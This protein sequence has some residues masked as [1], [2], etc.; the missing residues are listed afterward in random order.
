MK[1]VLSLVLSLALACG[2][3]VGL[4]ACGGEEK[5]DVVKP[6]NGIKTIAY[7][8]MKVGLITLHDEK[9]TYDLNFI[10]AFK[11]ACEAKGVK[12]VITRNI[13]ETNKAY[14][15]AADLVDQGCNLIFADSFGHEPFILKAA[16][17]FPDVQFC[18]AAGVKAHGE[19]RGNFHD[20]F[21]N[22]YEG[23]FLAGVAGGEKIKELVA[24]DANKVTT[25]NGEKFVKIGYV[26]AYTYAEV[27]SGY[28][29]FY[30]GVKYALKGQD[31]GV[32]MEVSFTGSWYDE[33]AEK[34]TANT[35]ITNGAILVSQHADS[36]GAPT[37]CEKAGVP[38]VSY[39][40]ST[41][42]SCPNTFIVSSRINWQPY[43]EYAMECLN[44]GTEIAYDWTAG[45]NDTPFAGSVC[46][47]DFGAAAASTTAT[48][49]STAFAALKAGTLKVFDVS[50]F[51][52]EGKAVSEH[53]VEGTN[54][55]KTVNG[56]TYFDESSLYS[57]PYFDL[58]IDGIKLLNTKY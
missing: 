5:G 33:T 35:L 44:S 54:V 11:A 40:G 16:K 27:V 55:I 23:R 2:V 58:K 43:Y 30:L 51:T 25:E 6:Y 56:I 50:T 7:S 34:E 24:A 12:S 32:K 39:N 15:A 47:T 49:V 48:A 9:S 26:G 29:S 22:I 21:A 13:P 37:A 28:T 36:M 45:M 18:H 53:V 8:D 20:A 1:K 19:K 46:L 41:E 17:E 52:V 4:T 38:N 14:E 31:Y 3:L 10:N 57:A 42:A